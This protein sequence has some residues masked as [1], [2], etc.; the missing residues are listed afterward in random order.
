MIKDRLRRHF[1]STGFQRRLRNI[2]WPFIKSYGAAPYNKL[3]NWIFRKYYEEQMESGEMSEGSYERTFGEELQP[4][5]AYRGANIQPLNQEDAFALARE[6]LIDHERQNFGMCV[7]HTVKNIYRFAAKAIFDGRT[8]YAEHDVYLD[9]ETRDK[10]IDAGMSSSRT[11]DRVVEKGIAIDGI[12]PDP[13]S[14]EDLKKLRSDYPDEVVQPFRQ[15]L[16]K[17]RSYYNARKDFDKLWDY[18]TRTYA[19]RGVRPF[20][21]SITAMRGWW[22]SDVPTATGKIYGGHSVVGLTIPFYYGNKRAFI[23]F[24]SS[25]RNGLVWQIDTGVRIVTED[26]WNGLGRAFRPV[27]FIDSV[28]EALGGTVD[29]IPVPTPPAVGF[30]TVPVSR[31]MNNQFVTD[32]Q[33]ALIHLG[34]SIP[35]IQSGAAQYGYYGQQ[36]ANAV[37][38]FQTQHAARFVA[39]DRQWTLDRLQQLRGNY[40]GSVSIRVINDLLRG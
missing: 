23:A 1:R 5:T 6:Y 14:K 19:E 21:F 37:M 7:A 4:D 12:V 38:A 30:V 32:L 36:T 17:S 25:F 35:A 16:L 2:Y 13:E 18:V 29:P 9:R 31:D 22:T 28:E 40:F 26:C 33:K 39:I 11:L 8:D 27:E 10:D 20:Q 34:F 15:K 24:D 3:H